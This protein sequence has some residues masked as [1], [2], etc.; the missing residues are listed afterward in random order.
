[1]I[2]L[3]N[4]EMSNHIDIELNN[5]VQVQ[6]L[7]LYNLTKNLSGNLIKYLFLVIQSMELL[8]ESAY[9]CSIDSSAYKISSEA[10]GLFNKMFCFSV[11][12]SSLLAK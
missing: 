2:Y 5:W 11:F 9:R 4:Q 12:S 7:S 8:C 3:D 10:N 1:M 6:T